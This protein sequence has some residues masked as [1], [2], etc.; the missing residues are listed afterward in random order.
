M[1]HPDHIG[2]EG[3][4]LFSA[5]IYNVYLVFCQTPSNF[6]LIMKRSTFSSLVHSCL[7]THSQV[8]LVDNKHAAIG[9]LDLCYGRWDTHTHPLADV[10]PTDL[11]KTLFPGQE[12]N[13]GRILDFN[14]VDKYVSNTL[15]IREY[16][17]MP[18]HDVSTVD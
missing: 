7:P 8:V 15:S 9:G 5:F 17:R 6:G 13:N 11:S 18:W 16:A 1:R 3:S 2:G 4:T 14:E 12:Y 10:H